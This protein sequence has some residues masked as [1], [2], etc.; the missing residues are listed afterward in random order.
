MGSIGYLIYLLGYKKANMVAEVKTFFAT[1]E[2]SYE[3][4]FFLLLLMFVNWGTEVFKWR[5][6]VR[7]LF[8]MTW[9]FAIKTQLCSIAG[10]VFTPYR[11][12]GYFGKVALLKHEYREKGFVLQLFNAMA[13]FITN[14]FFGLLFIAL[15]AMGADGEVY[16]IDSDLITTFGIIGVGIVFVFWILFINVNM[17]TFVF[18][19]VRWTRK[20]M[21]Y[22]E[23]LEGDNYKKN[24]FILLLVSILRY[25]TITYQYVLAFQVFGINID[26]YSLF[27]ASGA[28][29]FIF[30]FLPVFNAFE[31][32]A[33]RASVFFIILQAY[34][35]VDVVEGQDVIAMTSAC[36][37]IWVVNLAIPCLAGS[38]YL[39][40]MKVLKEE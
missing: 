38:F 16:G 13:M 17:V 37:F 4:L 15:L 9:S 22:W 21:E 30:Q 29:F 25:A 12:G 40:K 1:Q 8:P 39:S 28:L 34:G 36:F 19:K 31:L 11:I 18:E 32:G 6:L 7:S 27:L 14:F 35:I 20:W 24:A 10:S 26:Q 5:L 3:K 2:F 23:V 33:T